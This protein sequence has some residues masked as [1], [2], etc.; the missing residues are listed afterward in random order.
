MIIFPTYIS[1]PF[2]KSSRYTKFREKQINNYQIPQRNNGENSNEQI[3]AD[4]DFL[5]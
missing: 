1:N 2:Q 4:F 5:V 3:N